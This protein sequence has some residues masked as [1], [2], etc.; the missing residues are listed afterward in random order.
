MELRGIK[1]T[2]RPW[3]LTD[4]ASLIRHADNRNVW[5]NLQDGFPHPYTEKAAGE[6]LDRC[7]AAAPP[8]TAFAIE[9]FGE[10]VGG[11]GVE[12]QPSIYRV[13]ALAGYWLGE[14]FWGRGIASEACAL[15][16]DYVF[17]TFPDIHRIEAVVYEWNPA[18][19]R[20]L[21]KCGFTQ[22]ARKRKA[23]IKDGEII[24]VMLYAITR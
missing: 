14:P 7:A 3:R 22:E 4:Q 18:S 12:I 10:A 16:R 9:V 11:I 21:E 20:V 17:E 24:D 15:L 19:M 13:T 23:A 2:L 1:C 5:R 6:W 8:Q